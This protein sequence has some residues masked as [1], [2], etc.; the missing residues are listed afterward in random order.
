MTQLYRGQK[1]WWRHTRDGITHF[2]AVHVLAA[3]PTRV[4]VLVRINDCPA[5]RTVRPGSLL[6]YRQMWAAIRQ[7]MVFTTPTPIKGH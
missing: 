7:S 3:T 5:R 4:I 2:K 1:F 6:T